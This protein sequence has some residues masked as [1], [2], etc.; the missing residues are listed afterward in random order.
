MGL[1][2]RCIAWLRGDSEQATADSSVRTDAFPDDYTTWSLFELGKA[3]CRTDEKAVAEFTRY[4]FDVI[5]SDWSSGELH[6]N[7]IRQCDRLLVMSSD[8]DQLQYL[9]QQKLPIS[10]QRV[11]MFRDVFFGL[12]SDDTIRKALYGLYTE[13]R[14]ERFGLDAMFQEMYVE[15][16][17][18]TYEMQVRT[19]PQ[20]MEMLSN[21]DEQGPF[22]TDS[23]M[24]EYET[25]SIEMRQIGAGFDLT[26]S[27]VTDTLTSFI[28]S[29][30]S[31]CWD[32]I[33]LQTVIEPSGDVGHE[34]DVRIADAIQQIESEYGRP[35][36]AV[37]CGHENA[38]IRDVTE[39]HG[40]LDCHLDGTRYMSVPLLVADRDQFGYLLTAQE[41]VFEKQRATPM[42]NAWML[43][44]VGNYTVTDD[45]MVVGV[46]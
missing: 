24:P 14:N 3:M 40:V 45:A 18:H 39:K 7:H 25:K 17:T 41:P 23:E 26:E 36:T 27:N 19:D 6:P 42:H 9:N 15:D 11:E 28:D 30:A 12:F 8:E 44:W 32:T 2:A 33:D 37:V 10:Q 13:M 4:E 16:N 22:T 1:W 5:L 29:E 38:F 35:D 20:P 43:T 21:I 31:L 34:R 46:R